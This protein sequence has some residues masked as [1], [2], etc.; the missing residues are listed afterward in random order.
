MPGNHA[1]KR[2]SS[3]LSMKVYGLVSVAR[4]STVRFQLFSFLRKLLTICSVF[5][6]LGLLLYRFLPILLVTV[7]LG[8][9]PY[10]ARG[11]FLSL[12]LSLSAQK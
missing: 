12:L 2:I 5:P 6:I 8:L 4:M 9:Q 11:Y 10:V 3:K 1:Y 7:V